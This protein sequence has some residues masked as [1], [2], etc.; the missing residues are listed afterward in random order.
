MHHCRYTDAPVQGEKLPRYSV[1]PWL[2]ECTNDYFGVNQKRLLVVGVPMRETDESDS[3]S[4]SSHLASKNKKERSC[5]RN[6]AAVLLQVQVLADVAE[7]ES[8]ESH[9]LQLRLFSLGESDSVALNTTLN[10]RVG[11]LNVDLPVRCQWKST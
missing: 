8:R 5:W 4:V 6:T 9:A 11:I 2:F 7:F 3:V 1:R 10:A